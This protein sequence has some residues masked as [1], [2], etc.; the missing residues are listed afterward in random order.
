MN[1]TRNGLSNITTNSISILRTA[2]FEDPDQKKAIEREQ[3]DLQGEF[4]QYE[5]RISEFSGAKSEVL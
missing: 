5:D 1:K 3:K 4:E 2:P